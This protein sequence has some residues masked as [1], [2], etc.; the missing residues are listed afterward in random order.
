[1]K[2]TPFSHIILMFF[3]FLTIL[4]KKVKDFTQ[5]L[6]IINYFT[7]TRID[8][9]WKFLSFVHIS[10]LIDRRFTAPVGRSAHTLS[11]NEGTVHR[12]W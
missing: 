10:Y 6:Q 4:R 7:N 1:M 12:F 11:I 9:L 2:K 5:F 3:H 8:E